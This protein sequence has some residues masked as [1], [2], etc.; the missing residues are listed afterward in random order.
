MGSAAHSGAA[1]HEHVVEVLDPLDLV[2]LRRGKP[3]EPRQVPL[4][5]GDVLVVPPP[6]G[7]HDADSITLLSGPER[8]DAAT[9]PRADDEYVVV[10]ASHRSSPS[11]VIW[12]LDH[13]CLRATHVAP[14]STLVWAR[15]NRARG[16]HPRV[17]Q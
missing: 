2:E 4:A 14:V 11:R 13:R 17:D 3:Q 1:E 16:P 12:V 7:L 15:V 8:S 10:E 9:E 5:L 6:A